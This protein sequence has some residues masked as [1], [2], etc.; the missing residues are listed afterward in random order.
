MVVEEL[1]IHDGAKQVFQCPLIA[2][3]WEHGE[4]NKLRIRTHKAEIL[5][6]VLVEDGGLQDGNP[7][8]N[9][10]ERVVPEPHRLVFWNKGEEELLDEVATG[11]PDTCTELRGASLGED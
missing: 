8:T 11:D 5:C 10:R 6:L 9:K 7:V 4:V 2:A 3:F 1:W